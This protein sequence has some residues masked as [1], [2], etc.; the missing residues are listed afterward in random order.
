MENYPAAGR[1][2]YNCKLTSCSGSCQL[3]RDLRRQLATAAASAQARGRK[4]IQLLDQVPAAPPIASNISDFTF[5]FIIHDR[6]L[7]CH[8]FLH[9][10]LSIA[11]ARGRQV[12]MPWPLR[13]S[14]P[15]LNAWS[16]TAAEP[17]LPYLEGQGTDRRRYIC[18]Y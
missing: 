1:Y 15:S 16:Q 3:A 11:R 2:M 6:S 14:L 8:G 13:V 10:I 18:A 7:Q 17:K 4:Q 12:Q 9:V 5:K